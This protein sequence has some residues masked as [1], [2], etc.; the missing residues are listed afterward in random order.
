MKQ[1]AT[2]KYA[3][4]ARNAEH[5]QLFSTLL[6]IVTEEFA[7]TYKLTAFRTAFAASFAKENDA[8]LQNQA[9]EGTKT[10]EK[11]NE[12]CDRRFRLF[13]RNVEVGE[14]SDTPAEVEA[15]ERIA[16]AMKPYKGAPGKP[17]AENIAMVKDMIGMLESDKYTSDVETLG[18]TSVLASLKQ[19]VVDFEKAYAAR[20]GERLARVSMDDMKTVRP[21]VEQDFANL[22][23]LITALYLVAAHVDK[24]AERTTALEAVVDRLNALILEYHKK[25]ARRGIGSSSQ[26]VSTDPEGGEDTEGAQET[27]KGP[28]PGERPGGL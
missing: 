28:E 1:V 18:L 22:A 4:L 2:I 10:V 27:G 23:S 12:T 9:F 21:V 24:D 11:A 6:A 25:L 14:L 19:S 26:T 3:G 20:A 15:A 7:T 16:F 13:E 8:Y 17:H 5:Y